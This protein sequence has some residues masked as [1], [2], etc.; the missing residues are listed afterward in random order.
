MDL[1]AGAFGGY[2][3]GDDEVELLA[4]QLLSGILEQVLGLGGEAYDNLFTLLARELPENIVRFVQLNGPRSSTLL[5]F[6][7]CALCRRVVCG[8]GRGDADIALSKLIPG[9]IQH[10]PRR[11]HPDDFDARGRAN[12]R[13]ACNN[14]YA[15]AA[16]SRSLSQGEPHFAG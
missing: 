11:V 15:R 6:L 1:E 8:G 10:V 12:G 4:L 2:V 13:V 16:R 14:S 9:S 5:A 7:R 3:V